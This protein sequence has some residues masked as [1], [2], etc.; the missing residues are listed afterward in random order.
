MS[1]VSIA[2][3]VLSKSRALGVDVD[4]CCTEYLRALN[5]QIENA[6]GAD[7]KTQKQA[8]VSDFS[9]KDF[10]KWLEREHTAEVSAYMLKYALEFRDCLIEGKGERLVALS[11]GKQRLV[12]ASLSA[13]AKFT[14]CYST[15]KA[16]IKR[17]DLKWSGKSKDELVI[18]RYTSVKEPGEIFA[19]IRDV[20]RTFGYLSLF[21]DFIAVSGLRFGEAVHSY[22]LIISE[23]KARGVSLVLDETGKHRMQGY[24]DFEKSALEH[25]WFKELFLRHTKKA[26][27]SFVP[28]EM[29][30]RICR[31]IPLSASSIQNTVKRKL[32]LRFSDVREAH[33]TF[34]TKFLKSSEVDF[35]HGRI[36][37]TVFMQ[38]YFNLALIHDLE[39]RVFRGV[40][41]L[42]EL[43]QEG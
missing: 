15:W 14:G 10:K 25:F 38:H 42:Q 20:K 40:A 33:G 5:Q 3:D 19:W 26:F 17:Y 9:V 1:N 37:S 18:D 11:A 41:E 28:R 29:V 36:T 30:L 31:S 24:Y 43:I 21:M 32:P 13:L 39:A 22:N 6:L 35:I 8:G 27:I 7:T 23:A 34:M 2:E 16:L 12:M 4:S